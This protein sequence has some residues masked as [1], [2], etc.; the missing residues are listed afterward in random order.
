[1]TLP[2][3]H[4]QT[5]IINVKI[6]VMMPNDRKSSLIQ[7]STFCSLDIFNPAQSNKVR[8]W[9]WELGAL[10]TLRGCRLWKVFAYLLIYDTDKY[11][12]TLGFWRHVYCIKW[13]NFVSIII[14]ISDCNDWWRPLISKR[15]PYIY[16]FKPFNMRMLEYLTK[17]FQLESNIKTY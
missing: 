10:I 11:N 6:D 14:Y 15:M 8:N 1:M 16:E 17:Q 12:N 3:R 2:V 9:E 7:M 5:I 4:K 13:N